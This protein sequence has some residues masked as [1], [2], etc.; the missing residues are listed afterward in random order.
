[1]G[2][3]GEEVWVQR[4]RVL[5]AD[6]S[7]RPQ[8]VRMLEQV[9]TV[10]LLPAWPS[11]KELVGAAR[12]VDAILSRSAIISAPVIAAAPQLKVVSRHG[13]GLDYVDVEAC[14]R[15]GVLVTTTGDANSEAVSEQA[16]A[17]LFAVA[18]RVTTADAAMRLGEWSSVRPRV[19]GVELHR[20]VFGIVGLGR[21]GSRVAKHAHGFDMEVIACDPYIDADRAHRFGATLT[22]LETL[23]RRSD[24]VSMHVPL[25]DETRGMI[26]RAELE[27]IKPSAVLINTS[28]GPVIDEEALIEALTTRRIAGAGLD[29][30]AQEPLP[31]EH[32]LLQLDN[33]VCSPHI[34]GQTEE[35]MVGMS[36]R[37]A[38]NIL[39]VLRG[40]VPPFVAN[41]EVIG[42]TSRVVWK[43]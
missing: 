30:Y 24:V 18:R 28:R 32:P 42:Q 27:F 33:V 21:I 10:T 2:Y 3:G 1:M 29:V 38:E 7:L 35:A 40:Q 36:V 4:H 43:R 26:G 20:K 9:T 5:V 34:A 6:D 14:T 8:G 11:E 15:H 22:D 17:L 37:A 41:P 39:C 16:F 12:N 19:V 23:L 13:V 31:A 25:T